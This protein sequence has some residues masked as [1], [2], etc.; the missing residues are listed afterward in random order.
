MKGSLTSLFGFNTPGMQRLSP[1]PLTQI[2]KAVFCQIVSEEAG[3]APTFQAK[4]ATD[5]TLKQAKGFLEIKYRYYI[6]VVTA[7][8]RNRAKKCS[9][10]LFT[11]IYHFMEK[12]WVNSLICHLYLSLKQQ[13]TRTKENFSKQK[14]HI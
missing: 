1:H 13:L 5:Y 8:Q 9:L 14:I 4:S 3:F 11:H 7:I 10:S 6:M 2:F 12:L